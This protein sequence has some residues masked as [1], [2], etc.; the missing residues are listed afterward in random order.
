MFFYGKNII[1]CILKGEMPFKMHKMIFISRKKNKKKC[2]PTLPK[3][4]RPVTRNPLFVL[5]D[6]STDFPFFLGA[7]PQEMYSNNYRYM[8]EIVLKASLN[9]KTTATSC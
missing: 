7:Y 8:A 2:V 1:L 3:M 5:F 4:F 6:F 9:P